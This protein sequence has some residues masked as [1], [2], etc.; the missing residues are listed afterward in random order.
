VASGKEY[1]FHQKTE[2]KKRPTEDDVGARVS[3][4]PW[5]GMAWHM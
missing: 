4:L 2:K 1:S 3:H 5:H